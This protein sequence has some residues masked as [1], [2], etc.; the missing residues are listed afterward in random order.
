MAAETEILELRFME[1]KSQDVNNS[2][3]DLINKIWK[4]Y[5]I[6][7]PWECNHD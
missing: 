7:A 3:Y 5:S 1:N 6:E 4:I 2:Q